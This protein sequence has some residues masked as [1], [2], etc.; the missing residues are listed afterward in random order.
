MK[1]IL[2]LLIVLF[3]IAASAQKY[4]GMGVFLP[5]NQ[6][7]IS[8]TIDLDSITYRIDPETKSIIQEIWEKDSLYQYPISNIDSTL[9]ATFEMPDGV[10]IREGIGDWSEMRLS[11][12]GFCVLQKFYEDSDVP[13]KLVMF[14]R[15]E[16]GDSTLIS[17][18]CEQNGNPKYICI[19]DYSIII[20][21][22][23]NDSINFLIAYKDSVALYYKSVPIEAEA[24]AR[25][26][27]PMH[28]FGQLNWPARITA[29]SQLLLGAGELALLPEMLMVGVAVTAASF[30]GSPIIGLYVLGFVSWV[31]SDA[32]LGALDNFCTA[33]RKIFE[34]DYWPEY[35]AGN[36]KYANP[37]LSFLIGQ[38][39]DY[40]SK[41]M[42]SETL[43]KKL[44]KSG[45]WTAILTLLGDEMIIYNDEHLGRIYTWDTYKNMYEGWVITG[46]ATQN[47]RRQTIVEAFVSPSIVVNPKNNDIIDCEYG[48]I[49]YKEGKA[50]DI[51][52]WFDD[53]AKNLSG[54]LE[55]TLEGLE[56]ETTYDYQAYFYDRENGIRI[57]G[58]LRSFTTPSLDIP[59]IVNFEVLDAE[60][61]SDGFEYGDVSYSYK[62][63]CSLTVNM[64]ATDGMEDWGYIY[65][66][67]DGNESYISLKGQEF[68]YTDSDH[69]YYRKRSRSTATFCGYVKYIND[70]TIYK[71]EQKTYDL[72]YGIQP[73]PGRIVDLG[74][75]VKWAGWNIGADYPEEA[76][77]YVAWGEMDAKEDYS[78]STYKYSTGGGYNLSYERLG[79]N[80]AYDAAYKK[81][82]KG[83]RRP[84]YSEMKELVEKCRTAWITYEGVYGLL[85]TGPNGNSIFIPAV[86]YY[87][88]S[89]LKGY[90]QTGCYWT[91]TEVSGNTTYEFVYDILVVSTGSRTN[92]M[93][94]KYYGLPIRAVY[95]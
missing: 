82:G 41:E 74:L 26:M 1:R 35:N 53:E 86:G 34:T 37:V 11:K 60:Y 42:L 17:M 2:S 87:V 83:F 73:T 92:D 55:A 38:S 95:K 19:D 27:W 13:E 59:E 12:D 78:R 52:R 64:G 76:G 68:P 3:C 47:N 67:T 84:T 15:G 56:P 7:F 66:G 80:L 70:E 93:Q 65:T 57:F 33:L 4:N 71:G 91:S 16:N 10:I 39:F 51:R 58:E 62:Y 49:I 88:G 9:F 69:T 25:G 75:S 46:R 79:D 54:Y 28:S 29:I 45:N 22:I 23:Y 89:E 6:S 85:F 36:E 5:N 14:G 32:L 18:S 21:S 72:V 43:Y 61:V 90:N 50:K 94:T 81:W 77:D 8:T 40:V 63:D 30:S 24:L 44:S 48:I 20:D 31:L